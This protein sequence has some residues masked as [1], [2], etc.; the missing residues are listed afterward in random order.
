MPTVSRRTFLTGLVAGAGLL[1]GCATTGSSTRPV[2]MWHLFSGADGKVL[3]SMLD[4][5]RSRTGAVEATCLEWGAPY[6][7]KL[8]MASAGGRPP[9]LGV[10]HASRLAGYAPGGLLQPWDRQALAELGMT[11]D[12]FTPALWE[13]CL[14]GGEVFA[15]PLDTHPFIAFVNLEIAERAGLLGTDG[16]L[17]PIT[18]NEQFA[19]AGRKL[20][21]VTGEVG[22]GYGFLLDSASPWRLFWGL[23][24]QTGGEYRFEGRT[25]EW[26]MDKAAAVIAFLAPLFDDRVFSRSAEGTGAVAAFSARRRGMLLS[27]E[28]ELPTLAKKVKR[29]DAVPMPTM[30][31]KPASYADAHTFVLP[32]RPGADA[33]RLRRTYELAAALVG[34]GQLW[35]QGG[36]IPSYLPIVGTPE[37][38]QLRPQ[39]SYASAAD[40]VVLDPPVWFA[41][42]GSEFQKQMSTRLQS[43]YLGETTPEQTARSML[44]VV[45]QLLRIPNPA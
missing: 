5:V 15:L 23:Y 43:G 38:Q 22:I 20:G 1:A 3:L 28:W 11:E 33:E 29:L 7:T 9:D 13:R 36:H 44:D 39:S 26:D 34:Q 10:M 45:T 17:A 16:K 27:G 12:R 19:A 32:R 24:N 31:G 30:F 4:A 14:Y 2:Q 8:A 21:E 18:S 6:Y 35:A 40:N 42:P 37:Y 25:A 41:G